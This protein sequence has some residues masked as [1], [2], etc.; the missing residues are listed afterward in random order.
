MNCH[1]F[2]DQHG[3][4]G[5]VSGGWQLSSF[6]QGY[7]GHPLEVYNSRCHYAGDAMDANGIPE[8]IGGDYNLDG[9]CNDHPNF[10]GSSIAAAYSH[11]SPANG[12]FTDNNE[13]GCGYAGAQSSQAA[14]AACNAAYGVSTPNSLFV[15]PPGVGPRYGDTGPKCVP[16]ALVQRSGTGP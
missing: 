16:G 4:V 6:Y 10:V 1:F 14:I 5:R 3:F 15:N 2:K 13:I 12:I 9:V 11:D 7:S 8:N